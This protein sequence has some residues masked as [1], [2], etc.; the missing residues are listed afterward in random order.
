MHTSYWGIYAGL[1]ADANGDGVLEGETW[2]EWLPCCFYTSSRVSLTEVT[3]GSY[4]E[5][6]TGSV[7]GWH[8][9][10]MVIEFSPS[11]SMGTFS[12]KADGASEWS[13]IKSSV[14]LG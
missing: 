14:A 9:F 7:G 4:S 2:E 3:C 13:I 12:Y 8:T 5:Q 6:V 11:C 1:G 10:H